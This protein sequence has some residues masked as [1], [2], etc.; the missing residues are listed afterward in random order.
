MGHQHKID[1]EREEPSELGSKNFPGIVK[2]YT[3]EMEHVNWE[4]K[5]SEDRNDGDHFANG[6]STLLLNC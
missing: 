5:Q 1:A 3:D 2:E 6:A 4:V